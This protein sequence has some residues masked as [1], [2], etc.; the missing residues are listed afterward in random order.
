[1]ISEAFEKPVLRGV[2]GRKKQIAMREET[3]KLTTN[4]Y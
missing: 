2:I 4:L 3:N 1:M